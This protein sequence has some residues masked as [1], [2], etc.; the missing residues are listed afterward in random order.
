M[1]RLVGR[2]GVAGSGG[3][4]HG[5]CCQRPTL[6]YHFIGPVRCFAKTKKQTSCMEP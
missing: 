6:F 3:A 5:E 2:V 4:I 1:G